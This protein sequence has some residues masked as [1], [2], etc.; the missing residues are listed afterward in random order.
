VTKERKL[1]DEK[2]KQLLAVKSA[3]VWGREA[4]RRSRH[5]PSFLCV[6]VWVGIVHVRA[7][8]A[9]LSGKRKMPK[10]LLMMKSWAAK[11][12][13]RHMVAKKQSRHPCVLHS[14]SEGAQTAPGEARTKMCEAIA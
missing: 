7:V 11:A 1:D 9:K 8:D 6:V 3:V 13:R 2:K 5:V 12:K 14:S 10:V 4:K